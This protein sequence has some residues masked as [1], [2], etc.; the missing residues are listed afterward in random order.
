[1]RSKVTY[2]M[3]GNNINNNNIDVI[4]SS[5]IYSSSYSTT[6]FSFFIEDSYLIN[7]KYVLEKGFKRNLEELKY[8]ITITKILLLLK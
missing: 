1:M 6:F 5:K 7:M 3:N 8:N 4:I 2:L